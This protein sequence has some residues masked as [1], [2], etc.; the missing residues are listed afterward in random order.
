MRKA[1]HCCSGRDPHAIGQTSSL[2]VSQ[3]AHPAFLSSRQVRNA[4]RPLRH[5]GDNFVVGLLLLRWTLSLA[6]L[7]RVAENW[8]GVGWGF[9]LVTLRQIPSPNLW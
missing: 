9:G 3:T 4:S 6:P 1:A 8:V 2:V 5:K 7:L